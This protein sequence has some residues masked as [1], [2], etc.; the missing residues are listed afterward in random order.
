MSN[1][2]AARQL[3]LRVYAIGGAIAALLLAG[4][5]WTTRGGLLPYAA[6]AS[7]PR[8]GSPAAFRL[9][10]A[11]RPF[12]WS[13]AV[14]DLNADG[15]ADYA[16]ADRVGRRASGAQYYVELSISGI[17]S[18]SVSFDAPDEALSVSLR[19]VDHD[20]DL[21]LVVTALVSRAVVG[22]W[23]NDGHG[24]FQP[25]PAAAQFTEQPAGPSRADAGATGSLDAA[26][27][28]TPRRF[29]D[30]LGAEPAAGVAFAQI[31]RPTGCALVAIRLRR[32]AHLRSRAP[33]SNTFVLTPRRSQQL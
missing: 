10:T 31:D 21:D 1:G 4:T 24:R 28:T 30:G 23:L 8:D 19:D 20:H 16:V 17:G 5:C 33:P 27:D 3:Q 11:G 29:D 14:G 32:S 12:G 2:V 13:T 26:A 9:G 6:A 25:A 22:V 15:R 18:R 7:V